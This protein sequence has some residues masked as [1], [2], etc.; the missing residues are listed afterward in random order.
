MTPSAPGICHWCEQRH[1][2]CSEC[3]GET[4]CDDDGHATCATCDGDCDDDD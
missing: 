2:T 3:G 4:G 1:E